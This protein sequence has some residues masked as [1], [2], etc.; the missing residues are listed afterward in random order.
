MFKAYKDYWMRYADFEGRSTR[1]DYWWVYLINAII[2]AIAGL[3]LIF[4]FILPLIA[5][6]SYSYTDTDEEFALRFLSTVSPTVIIIFILMSC[7]SLATIVPNLALAVR[8]LRDAGYHWSVVLISFL[9]VLGS[10]I[11]LLNF[12][13]IFLV[14]IAMIVIYCQPSK[15]NQAAVETLAERPVSETTETPVASDVD[16]SKEAVSEIFKKEET[17]VVEEV[18]AEEVVESEPEIEVKEI[19]SEA[20]VQP[21]VEVAEPTTEEQADPE[22]RISDLKANRRRYAGGNSSKG[23]KR[24]RH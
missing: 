23:Y 22:Q 14:P 4:S 5:I 24:N 20:P 17:V 21:K 2:G 8:R 6:S 16:L 3:I 1:S 13:I 18:S 7:Y 12:F 11:P 15:I 10:W 9:P 19:V